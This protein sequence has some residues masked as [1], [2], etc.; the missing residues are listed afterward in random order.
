MKN[1]QTAPKRLSEAIDRILKKTRELEKSPIDGMLFTEKE[2]M[3]E[4]IDL[5]DGHFEADPEKAYDL[6]YAGIERTLK[7][8]LPNDPAVKNPVRE[9]KC[10]LLTG[11]EKDAKGVRGADS[12]M[13]NISTLE[14]LVTIIDEWSRTSINPMDLAG[15]L[16][17]KNKEL[18]YIP[19]ER[20][21]ED[22]M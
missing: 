16:L 18:G 12:R 11:K 4:L 10:I 20:E 17:Q 6:Y 15:L 7:L 3:A 8:A 5:S 1:Q 22:Y 13:Q 2:E 9:L 14:N 19:E 21:I